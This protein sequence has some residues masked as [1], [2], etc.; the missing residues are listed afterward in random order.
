MIYSL[1]ESSRAPS[2]FLSAS[3]VV[4]Y[5]LAFVTLATIGCAKH[6]NSQVKNN[7]NVPGYIDANGHLVD[8]YSSILRSRFADNSTLLSL[9]DAAD[10]LVGTKYSQMDCSAFAKASYERAGLN[11]GGGGPQ[12]PTADMA[13]GDSIL[14]HFNRLAIDPASPITPAATDLLGWAPSGDHTGHVVIVIDPDNCVIAHSASWMW[15]P[16][17]QD[18]SSIDGVAFNKIDDRYCHPR[19]GNPAWWKLNNKQTSDWKFLLQRKPN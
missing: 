8:A 12:I 2:R 13:S 9:I 14:A 10:A 18:A 5:L 6:Q 19:S 11:F 17:I 15:D 3:S 7:I 4:R 16:T 1:C